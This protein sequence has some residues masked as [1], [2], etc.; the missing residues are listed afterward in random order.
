[1]K[2]AIVDNQ[3]N[4]IE[5]AFDY[6]NLKFYNN[7][8][9][10]EYFDSSQSLFKVEHDFDDYKIIVVD[11]SLSR[12]SEL[13]GYGIIKTFLEKSK[14]SED[15]HLL[16]KVIIITGHHR[17][18]EKLQEQGL[19]EIPIIYKPTDFNQIHEYFKKKGLKDAVPAA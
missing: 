7:S 14:E 8:L 13:D 11:I 19:P 17:V 16:D 9:E 5:G 1:M 12:R 18:E 10:F 2:I 3:R 6:A 15:D 4:D